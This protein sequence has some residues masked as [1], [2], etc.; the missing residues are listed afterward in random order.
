VR[1]LKIALQLYLSLLIIL[2]LQVINKN[3][4]ATPGASIKIRLQ[5]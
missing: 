2:K 4:A 3:N 5:L 1:L